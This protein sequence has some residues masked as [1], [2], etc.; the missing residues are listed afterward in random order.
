MKVSVVVKNS[1]CIGEEVWI[2]CNVSCPFH[3]AKLI[4]MLSVICRCGSSIISENLT[5]V[6]HRRNA[7]FIFRLKENSVRKILHR[8]LKRDQDIY[9]KLH[10]FAASCLT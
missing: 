7:L 1:F 3:F 4:M 5:Q 10:F 8:I 6:H 2:Y 9:H